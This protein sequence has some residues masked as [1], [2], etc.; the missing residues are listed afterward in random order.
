MKWNGLGLLVITM[1]MC[2]CSSSPSD[3]SGYEKFSPAQEE[4]H[5]ATTTEEADRQM[6]NCPMCGGTGIYEYMPGDV[7][8]PVEVCPGCEGQKVVTAERAQKIMEMQS[9]VSGMVSTDGAGRTSGS[10]RSAYEI[11]LELRK[12][13]EMLEDMERNYQQCTSVVTQAQYPR[14]IA[15]QKQ[16]IAQLE[17]E[18]QNAQ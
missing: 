14:M 15:E 4:N 5:A 10:G 11:E 2:A 9:Q 8:A 16:Y 17:A 18:W 3:Y 6:Y 13:Y 7:M 1:G 12:A